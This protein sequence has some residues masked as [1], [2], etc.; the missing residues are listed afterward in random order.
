MI[1]RSAPCDMVLSWFQI[2]EV[3]TLHI[4]VAEAGGIIGIVGLTVQIDIAVVGKV[5][6]PENIFPMRL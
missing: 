3:I 2:R 4:S 5:L 6:Q 1:Y